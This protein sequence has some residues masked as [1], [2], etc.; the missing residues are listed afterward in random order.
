V[1]FGNRL[2]YKFHRQVRKSQ[3]KD[4]ARISILKTNGF[5]FFNSSTE[6]AG[7]SVEIDSISPGW[8]IDDKRGTRR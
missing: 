2:G 7:F 8:F 4:C 1:L 5:V 3:T 6:Y